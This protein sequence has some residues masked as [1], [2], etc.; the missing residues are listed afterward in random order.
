ME[1]L[2]MMAPGSHEPLQKN[3]NQHPQNQRPELLNNQVNHQVEGQQSYE[4]RDRKAIF[5]VTKTA[6]GYYLT[7]ATGPANLRGGISREAIGGRLSPFRIILLVTKL[8]EGLINH[9]AGPVES[10]QRP[11]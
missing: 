4:E 8:R 6:H 3:A 2:V 1:V 11:V 9:L 5:S 7:A 10:S